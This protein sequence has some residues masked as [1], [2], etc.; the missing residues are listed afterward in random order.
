MRQEISGD[1]ISPH[2]DSSR[3]LLTLPSR[4]LAEP[5][6]STPSRPAQCR[7]GETCWVVNYVDVDSS[8]VAKDFH[9]HERT[10]DGHDRIFW[11]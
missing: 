6:H 11:S 8:M 4:L 9:C 7:L 5:D 3:P 2:P 10:Y 1:Q